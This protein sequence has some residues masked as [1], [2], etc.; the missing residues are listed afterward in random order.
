[1]PLHGCINDIIPPFPST[2]HQ[3]QGQ[4]D[5]NCQAMRESMTRHIK[6]KLAKYTSLHR[7]TARTG[8][9]LHRQAATLCPCPPHGSHVRN[10][11][12]DGRVGHNDPD[13]GQ[14]KGLAPPRCHSA[15]VGRPKYREGRPS[16][17]HR[18]CGATRPGLWRQAC[19]GKSTRGGCR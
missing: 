6:F 17:S 9:L 15:P 13:V 5:G 14:H 18:E 19:V 2:S 1:M 11:A 10:Q 16:R 7:P 12:R 3:P 8:C 4:T